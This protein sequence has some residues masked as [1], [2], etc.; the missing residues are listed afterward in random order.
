MPGNDRGLLDN[1]SGAAPLSHNTR[2]DKL[3]RRRTC[4]AFSVTG[5][6]AFCARKT[7]TLRVN[8]HWQQRVFYRVR[9]FRARTKVIVLSPPPPC[10]ATVLVREDAATGLPTSFT[11]IKIKIKH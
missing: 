5:N 3:Q 4:T 10:Q 2:W 7:T 8:A 11:C 6:A 1:D 9:H